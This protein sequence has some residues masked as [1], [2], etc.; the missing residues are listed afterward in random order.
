MLEQADRQEKLGSMGK[1][2]LHTVLGKLTEG[3]L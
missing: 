2:V 1:Q 3:K